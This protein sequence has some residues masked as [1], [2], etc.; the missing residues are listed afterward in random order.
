MHDIDR[1]VREF[2]SGELFEYES[3]G[4]VG[5]E[6]HEYAG[7]F[8]HEMNE[9]E[10]GHEMHEYSG[11][12]SHEQES[13]VFDEIQEMELAAELLEVTNEQELEQFL[14]GLLKKAGQAVGTFVKSP[15]GKQLGG[16]LKGVAKKALPIAGKALGNMIL[17]GV[18]GVIGGK[19]ASAAGS[20]FGLE[21]EGLSAED[22][23]FEVAR[24]VVRLGGAAVRNATQVRANASP[25]AIARAAL[26]TAARKHAPGLLSQIPG[27][28]AIM[29]ANGNGMPQSPVTVPT[30]AA[31]NYSNGTPAAGTPYGGSQ[32]R[33]RSGR[34][35][36]RGAKIVILLGD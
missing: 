9:N 30:A 16:M 17:P 32:P 20:L 7:E 2:E 10:F 21:L 34:W 35:I 23:E 24:R 4:E 13:E 22:R 12:F 6:A 31:A 1:T 5:H 18:G 27:A 26:A 15:V 14:G 33:R 3:F 36:R 19:L 25:N 28:A 11:E 29:G 8:G